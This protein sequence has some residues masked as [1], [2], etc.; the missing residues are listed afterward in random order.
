MLSME[1]MHPSWLQLSGALIFDSHIFR[2]YAWLRI[3]SG[4]VID[5]SGPSQ[6]LKRMGCADALV[7]MHVATLHVANC[8]R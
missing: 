5:L 1:F 6:S 3:I 7:S 4:S 8:Y 2:C